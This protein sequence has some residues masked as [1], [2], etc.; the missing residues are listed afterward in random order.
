MNKSRKITLSEVASAAGVSPITVSRALRD[1]AKVSP[2][3]R[4][5]IDEAIRE[6]G[7][8]PNPA[9]RALASGRTDVVGVII[10]SVSNN[11]FGD[12]T[13]GIYDAL[14]GSALSVQMGNTRYSPV[15]EE[16]LIRVFLSQRPAGLIVAGHD[17]SPA[18]RAALESAECPVVQLMEVG[19]APIDMAVG[20]SHYD[21]SWAGAAHLLEQ[22]YR[23]P[24]FLGA[25]MDPR[26]QRRLQAFRDC[27]AGAG[28]G[29]D[30]PVV[31]TPEPSS[32][33][34]GCRLF[35]DL[36]SRSPGTDAVLCNNDDI[37]LGVLF[38]ARRRN[39]RVPQDLGICGFNDLE[40][41]AAAEPAVSSVATDRLEMGRAAIGLIRDRL[42]GRGQPRGHA[43]DLGFRLMARASTRRGG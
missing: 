9:A 2:E 30:D 24:A 23:A 13:R 33:S 41:M 37:A 17:Q 19:P 29:I 11:V 36:L 25:Q 5:R 21:A 22:G 14:E 20:L 3:A 38:E 15:I 7:Y 26:S 12:V 32:V 34:L 39:L 31:T 10:P 18:A 35:A 4:A 1:P 16:K 28:I 40:M 27:L 6:L 42:A 43:L 8:V